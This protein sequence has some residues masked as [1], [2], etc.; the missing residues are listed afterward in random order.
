MPFAIADHNQRCK[1]EPP[2]TLHHFRGAVQT[3]QFFFQ[4]QALGINALFKSGPRPVGRILLDLL[5]L[6]RLL[7]GLISYGRL[8]R[9]VLRCILIGAQCLASFFSVKSLSP[10]AGD[11]DWLTSELQAA[12]AGSLG[13]RLHYTVIR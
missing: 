4:V 2:P 11:G 5:L 9:R 1:A 10:L 8:G 3:N 7:L 13:K 12:L 6:D